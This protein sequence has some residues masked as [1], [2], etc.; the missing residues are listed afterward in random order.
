[1]LRPD[2]GRPDLR[3]VPRRSRD[4]G[5]IGDLGG[6]IPDLRDQRGLKG[7]TPARVHR[8]VDTRFHLPVLMPP[9]APRPAWTA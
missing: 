7:K 1:M 3:E 2:C 5:E 6:P 8:S 9:P 4:P